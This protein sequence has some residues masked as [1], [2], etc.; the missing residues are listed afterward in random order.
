MTRVLGKL[1]KI[2]KKKLAKNWRIF[3]GKKNQQKK[4]ANSDLKKKLAKNWQIGVK[5]K[6]CRKILSFRPDWIKNLPKK[7]QIAKKKKLA[8]QKKKKKL[9]KNW[10]AE[11]N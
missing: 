2:K 8:N 3:L 6:I 9:A 11:K 5:S 4:L 7:G 1:A 10:R